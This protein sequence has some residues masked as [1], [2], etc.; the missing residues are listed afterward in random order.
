MQKIK[1]Q[2]AFDYLTIKTTKSRIQKGLL[3][4][5]S[6]LIDLFPKNSSKV[7][8]IN[9]QGKEEIKNFTPYNSSSREC[10]IGGLKNFYSKYKIKDG[11][12]LVI[13]FLEDSKFKIIPEKI[14]KKQVLELEKVIEKI[15]NEKEIE[16]TFK[17]LS[18]ITNKD[19]EEVI[20]NEF[21]RLSDQEVLA[22]K[23]RIKPETKTKESVPLSLRIILLKM[24]NGN[25]QVSNFTFL[26]RTGIPY[27]EIHH[28]DPTKGN[29]LK[30]LIV[31]S[32]NVHKQFTYSNL[33]Q[34]F[35]NEG[36]IRKVK[37][38]EDTYTVFQIIDKL[39]RFFEKEIH[40][41]SPH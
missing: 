12:E 36:W 28:I 11:D 25:C 24:Y 16:K 30:N 10:R 29:H 7:Y 20:K 1:S 35:D 14:F 22:R 2:I 27:F 31:V 21:V 18:D 4:I 19:S 5:P 6:S 32:P 37:F 9:E 15:N 13:Q 26:T 33:E 3:A 40:S 39:P 38:N 8:L 41:L 34:F 23:I 17:K